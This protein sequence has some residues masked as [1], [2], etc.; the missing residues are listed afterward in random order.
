M[1]K[2]NQPLLTQR[3]KQ[4]HGG[5]GKRKRGDTQERNIDHGKKRRDSTS[6]HSTPSRMC[7]P[8][9]EE[10]TSTPEEKCENQRPNITTMEK[11]T[12]KREQNTLKWHGVM[13]SAPR[14]PKADLLSHMSREPE[15][16][17]QEKDNRWTPNKDQEKKAATTD[18]RERNFNQPPQAPKNAAKASSTLPS[19]P[20]IKDSPPNGKRKLDEGEGVQSELAFKKQRVTGSRLP[21][22]HMQKKNW[23]PQKPGR[24][25]RAEDAF[26]SYPVAANPECT[27][28]YK[29]YN[30][31][32]VPI[33]ISDQI[34]HSNFPDLLNEPSP[35]LKANAFVL[36]ERG[37][38]SKDLGRSIAKDADGKDVKMRGRVKVIKDVDLYLHKDGKV[39]VATELGLILAAE[40][41]TLAGTPDT[42]PVRFNGKKP[43]WMQATV[44]RAQPRR[45]IKPTACPYEEEDNIAPKDSYKPVPEGDL[46]LYQDGTVFMYFEDPK[47]ARAFGER[48]D[49]NKTGKH[50]FI[51]WFDMEDAV[52]NYLPLSSDWEGLYIEEDL[53]DVSAIWV[54]GSI[55]GRSALAPVPTPRSQAGLGTS[56]TPP[57][58][59]R[60]TPASTPAPIKAVAKASEKA[61]TASPPPTDTIQKPKTVT[62]PSTNTIQTPPKQSADP[63][64]KSAAKADEQP[65][66]TPEVEEAQGPIA[67]Q[68]GK[69]PKKDIEEA[70]AVSPEANNEVATLAPATIPALVQR[71]LYSR[72]VEDEVDWDDNEL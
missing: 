26:A 45:A 13:A 62:P 28:V 53:W 40:Y 17:Q 35:K 50:K 66:K 57:A 12:P 32:S 42:Q 3:D 59:A 56:A 36:L 44:A 5:P 9:Q 10:H 48:N 4:W 16:N 46:G 39:Y 47:T 20:S 61:K 31:D 23:K 8:Y 64:N 22:P 29:H 30:H 69:E 41:L 25:P 18:D 7:T 67:K 60:T 14:R 43:A 55:P 15:A 58:S 34:Q 11:K 65:V 54:P 63:E 19:P 1:T 2:N 51:G 33:M 52:D 38:N 68:S 37:F 49:M 27:H 21:T 6:N 72:D 70:E 71:A 24:E